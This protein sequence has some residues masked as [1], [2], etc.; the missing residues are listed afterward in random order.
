[1]VIN[2]K[3]K[4]F[5][6]IKF[7]TNVLFNLV[8]ILLSLVC[9]FPVVFVFSISVSSESALQ[10]YGYRIIPT[11]FSS[12]AYQFLWNEKD[13][14]LHALWISI[15]VTGLGIVISVLL[16]TTMGYVLSRVNYKLREFYTWL[17]FIP[18]I[19]NGGMLASYVVNSNILHLRNTI[20]ALILPLAV[21]SFN[22][23]ICKTFFK[24]TIPDSIIESA[25]VDGASQ[26][27]I[28]GQIVLP[29]SKPILATIALFAAFG[30]WNDWFQASLY[31]SD[32]N[33]QSL[34][35]MLN[36]IQSNIEYIANNPYGGLSL[37]QYKASMP[38]ESVRMAI[39]IVIIVPIACVYPFFQKYF[40]SGLTIGSV[41]G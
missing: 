27:R 19:F 33:L 31:I 29:I 8:F 20:W 16:T 1:M 26:L 25:K 4:Q 32:S 9:I 38:T 36:N 37:Q 3:E 35:S 41:K 2:K 34:Q 5:N 28:F 6:Q 12:A 18:M 30:Y 10:K 11:E 17:V 7:S 24:T 23:V 40:I 21:S 15:L 14:I 13:T 39:A 22:V